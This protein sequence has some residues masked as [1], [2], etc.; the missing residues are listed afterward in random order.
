M[1]TTRKLSRR[2]FLGRVAGGAIVGGAALTVLG[3]RA[4]ALQV[5]DSDSGPNADPP[6][7]GRTGVTDSD[8]G[9]NSDRPGH[10]RRARSGV[11]DNDTG[12]GADPAGNGRGRRACSDS[13]TGNGSDPVSRGRRC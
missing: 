13:D 9:S 1:K 2:S 10:G 11:T 5:S 3:E 7:R 12:G 4:Q 6:G 8:S